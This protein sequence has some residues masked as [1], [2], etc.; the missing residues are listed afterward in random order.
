MRSAS[1]AKLILIV[2]AVA[3]LVSCTTY[4]KRQE[5][6]RSN[7][8][9]Q[10]ERVAQEGSYLN[11]DN[12]ILEC[13]RVDAKI[14][15]TQLDLGFKS[16]RE[17]YCRDESVYL[18]GKSGTFFNPE[19][20]TN[21]ASLRRKHT[22]G[23]NEYCQTSNGYNAGIVG[24]PYNKICPA[25]LEPGFLVEFNKGRKK[26]LSAEIEGIESRLLDLEKDISY[27]NAEVFRLKASLAAA[28]PVEE[29]VLVNK[30][31]PVTNSSN[32]VVEN[33]TNDQARGYRSQLESQISVAEGRIYTLQGQQQEL[34]EQKRKLFSE[35]TLL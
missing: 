31:D 27:Q 3:P 35:M 15:E 23:V 4:M 19:M 24:K 30:Y 22:Q 20:C 32:I 7:W 21:T 9:K 28:P 12:F 10:G 6:N 18:L 29:Q 25:N 2:S 17:A 34:R 13:R 26:Y 11:G 33:Q 5:C 1:F 8:F 14:D 16:G